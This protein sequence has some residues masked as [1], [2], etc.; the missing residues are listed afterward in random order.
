MKRNASYTERA[1]AID[2]VSEINRWSATRSRAIRSAG[3]EWG[4][5][6]GAG[7]NTLF[8]DVLLF[9]DASRDAVLQGWELKM[10]DTPV[11]DQALLD[12][13]WQKA[14]RL[15]LTSFLVWNAVDAVLYRVGSKGIAVVQT[16][17]CEGVRARDDVHRN[18]KAWCETLAA[19][20]EYVCDYIE[21]GDG[22]IRK[23]LPARLNDVVA[24]ILKESGGVLADR[25]KSECR[26][27]RQWRADVDSWWTEVK[28][29][30]SGKK[31]G[32][33]DA[34]RFPLLASEILLHWIHRFLFAHYLK[35][36]AS[37]ARAVDQL[38]GDVSIQDAEGVF[39]RIS[40]KRD[41]A[42][43]FKPRVGSGLLPD[44][45]WRL[46]LAFNDFLKAVRLPEID[47]G[48]FHETLQS[49]IRE[50]QRKV[51]GQF[52]TPMPLARLL[53]ALTVDDLDE[54]V[55]DP[56]CGTGTIARAVLDMKIRNGVAA[57]A[58]I[59][60][61][62]ASDLHAMPLQFSTLA[63][64]TGDAPFETVRVFQ[65]DALDLRQ[66]APVRFVDARDG[67]AF[68]EPLPSF[69]CVVVNPPF[70]RFEDWKTSSA[71]KK[72]NREL[73][74][75]TGEEIDAKADYFVAVILALRD[76]L[77]PDGRLGAVFPNSWL[78]AGWAELFRRQLREFFA[79]ETVVTSG[80]GRW[81]LNADVVTNLVVM[82]KRRPGETASETEE[83]A[84]AVTRRA[85][86]EWTDEVS[87]KI[88][89]NLAKN[90]TDKGASVSRLSSSRIAQFE[91][92][93]LCWSAF[94]SSLAWW[95]RV[96]QFLVPV[97]ENFCFARGERRGWDAMFYPPK[98]SGIEPEYLRPVLKTSATV[99]RLE[100]EPDALA[101][102]CSKTLAELAAL[103]HT[104]ASAWIRKFEAGVNEKGEPLPDV[105]KRAGHHWYEMRPDAV[106]DL[107]VSINPGNRLFFIRLSKQAFTNQRLTRL[108][109]KGSADIGLCHALLCSLTGCFYLEAMGFGRGLGA[110]DLSASKMKAKMWML[111]PSRVTSKNRVAIMSAFDKLKRR[112]VLDFEKEMDDPV[113]MDF[114]RVV[115]M[116][117]G[118]PD[119]LPQIRESVLALHRIR[120]ASANKGLQDFNRE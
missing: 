89:V 49:V 24:A 57:D 120:N 7:G 17:R 71:V 6:P 54:P 25:L 4:V 106:A 118:L 105:L 12:N 100:A 1:W 119:V 56:C 109:A 112:D 58:A 87:D 20:L 48:L 26:R 33:A 72:L 94:F 74:A 102:C 40:E 99:R 75:I 88:A 3:G 37:E 96:E 83:T 70:V 80:N 42:H 19:I 97:R 90:K 84:F 62:Y 2:L 13:A 55:L 45:T 47:Q 60:T 41:F 110:L 27:S 78:G 66:G 34:D 104:G 36:S 44:E 52:C 39:A 103:G 107:A 64:A 67:K 53:V 93:G 108:T 65:H 21:G 76:L 18:R 61:T 111:N 69:P 81:F 116:A 85:I 82:R 46:L 114:E 14:E 92:Y 10:P 11:T 113:R 86:G 9:G 91:N 5:A 117:F 59:R 8:P 15:G 16:W 31:G 23:P 28:A 43:V 50:S 30:H 35:R 73:R 101:F 63:L 51:S 29:A 22:A 38:T 98:D 95:D 79:I 115:L 77:P 32:V 68:E